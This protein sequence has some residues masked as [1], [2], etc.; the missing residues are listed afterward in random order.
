MIW[1][2]LLAVVLCVGFFKLGVFAVWFGLMKVAL[3]GVLVVT[4]A[5]G[6]LAAWKWVA[7]RRR[8]AQDERRFGCA[9]PVDGKAA[10]DGEI[11]DTH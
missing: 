8:I 5:A 4:C 9:R 11:L 10:L 1:L 2:V 3:Q 6:I 7:K